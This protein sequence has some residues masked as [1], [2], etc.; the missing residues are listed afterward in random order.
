MMMDGQGMGAMMVGMGL[1]WLLVLV[2]LALV[3]AAAIK[4]LFFDT[5]HRDGTRKLDVIGTERSRSDR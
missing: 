2:V 3:G 5:R 1:V 4:Y